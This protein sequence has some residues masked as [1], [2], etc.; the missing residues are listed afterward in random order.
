MAHRLI[1]G[2][3]LCL[4]AVLLMSYN[5]SAIQPVY[6]MNGYSIVNSASSLKMNCVINNASNV[7]VK[8]VTDDWVCEYNPTTNDNVA[9][10]RRF[11]ST[12]QWAFQ[13]GDIIEFSLIVWSSVNLSTL[14]GFVINFIGD[15]GAGLFLLNIEQVANNVFSNDIISI[16]NGSGGTLFNGNVFYSIYR[17]TFKARNDGVSSIGYPVGAQ[18]YFLWS[19]SNLSFRMYDVK[20]YRMTG[21]SSS[22]QQNEINATNDSVQESE[23]EG[24]TSQTDTDNT[25]QSLMTAGANIISA[26]TS[27]PATDCNINISTTGSSSSFTSA[28]GSLNLCSDVPQG[29][30][31]LVQGMVALVFTPLVL[32]YVYSILT[33][34]YAQFKEYNS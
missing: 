15:N 3:L 29:V 24:N 12:E 19:G 5:V 17:Y 23:N 18:D 34:I 11:Y 13:S 8:N 28:I 27:A 21:E 1:T 6:N 10:L 9:R 22:D 26:L 4:C 7:T 16:T 33:L 25:T 20:Q 2:I 32:Y 30:L 31:N 14:S